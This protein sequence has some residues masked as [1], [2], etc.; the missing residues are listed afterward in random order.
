MLIAVDN[1]SV[2]FRSLK[3]DVEVRS[4]A[5]KYGGGGHEKVASCLFQD[6][7]PLLLERV[8]K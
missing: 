2:S 8:L 6:I 3:D 1:Q 5:E 4:L 7:E